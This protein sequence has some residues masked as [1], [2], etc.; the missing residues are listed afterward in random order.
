MAS[1][2]PSIS[3]R[4]A[5]PCRRCGHVHYGLPAKDCPQCPCLGS[6]FSVRGC[7]GPC[8]GTGRPGCGSCDDVRVLYAEINRL[9]AMVPH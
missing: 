5:G 4:I 7:E 9:R 3:D 2:D 6:Q 8:R 1:E